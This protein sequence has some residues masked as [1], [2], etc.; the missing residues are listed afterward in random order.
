[1]YLVTNATI[2]NFDVCLSYFTDL[3]NIFLRNSSHIWLSTSTEPQPKDLRG[4]PGHILN[5]QH[6]QQQESVTETTS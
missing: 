1:M 6:K 3:H 2:Y 4:P 5:F